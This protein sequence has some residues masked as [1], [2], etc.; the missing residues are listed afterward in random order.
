MG[1][2]PS[3]PSKTTVV[4]VLLWRMVK[5]TYDFAIF[6]IILYQA[7]MVFGEVVNLL[8]GHDA[9]IQAHYLLLHHL[10]ELPKESE[11]WLSNNVVHGLNM[12]D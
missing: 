8:Q 4:A 9:L 10:H 3:Q 2:S 11:C 12:A 5:S 1:D 6:G 7:A